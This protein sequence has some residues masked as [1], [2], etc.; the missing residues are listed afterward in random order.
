[1]VSVQTIASREISPLDSI[2]VSVTKV[3]GGTAHNVTPD[4]M[5]V[6]G[7]IRALNLQTFDYAISRLQDMAASIGH[8]ARCNVTVGWDDAPVYP[9]TVNSPE[10][11]AF[12]RHV[13]SEYVPPA[14]G[15]LTSRARSSTTGH[16][17]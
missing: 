17:F 9:P 8:A 6:I 3:N 13:G 2:V 4:T 7:T 12:A 14:V 11:W 5:T 10:A 1:M 16:L 15:R